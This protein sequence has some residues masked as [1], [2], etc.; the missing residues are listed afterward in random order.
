M[1][2]RIALE[3]L[4]NKTLEI[5]ITPEISQQ[6]ADG[7]P[8]AIGVSGGK[9]SCAVAFALSDYLDSV[10]HAGERILIHS[11]LGRTEWKDSLPTC[12]RLAKVLGL[13]LIVVRRESGDMLARWQ[14]R[15]RNN[16][17]RY[18]ALEC[19]KLILPWST[20]SMRFCTSELKTAIISRYLAKRFKGQTVISVTGI[21]REESPAR[22]KKPVCKERAISSMMTIIDWHPILDFK[23]E[24]HV[25][26]LLKAKNFP[27]HEAYTVF[28]SSRVSCCFC[29]LGS[30]NDLRAAS[31]CEDNAELY[32]EMVALEIETT[33]SFQSGQW[34]G[35]IAPHLLPVGTLDLLLEAK[36]RARQREAAE[37]HI[38]K[39][40]LYVKGWPVAVPT[41]DEAVM[42][43]EVRHSVSQAV[44]IATGF[45]EPD[46]IIA[47]YQELINARWESKP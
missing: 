36:Q 42:L 44:G 19:V 21:R 33:F 22:A 14:Q 11:D 43:S 8:I 25:F 27:L 6:I 28:G 41:F 18:A 5:C 38:P 3:G 37:A 4:P 39:S 46:S 1:N 24:A 32:R 10:G 30:Q 31:K 34:L 2:N 29:I 40:M 13:E 20:P 7:A 9:D 15:W 16:V 35:D 26:P 45:T 12:E 47:R 17:A 23:M